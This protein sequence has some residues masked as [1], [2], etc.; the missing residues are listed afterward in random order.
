MKFSTSLTKWIAPVALLVAGSAY[1]TAPNPSEVYIE[2]IN[3]NGSGCPLGTVA[4]NLATD[5]KAFTLT[6]AE[7]IAEAG[8]HLSFRDGRKNCQLTID[9]HIPQGFQFS[10]GT[11]NYRGWVALDDGIRAAHT[12]SYYFQ[13]QGR[14]GRFNEYI[15][16]PNFDL[17]QFEEK[18]GLASLV[19]SPCGATRALN[20]NTSINVFNFDKRN[21]PDAQGAIGTD[22][23]D[24]RIEQKFGLRWRRCR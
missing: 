4:E 22:S 3:Y 16:G 18:V 13:G 12:T 23:I 14:T 15:W 11:F 10:I 24:G 7:Y 20:I 21:N 9:L 2:D 6:F 1:A 5:G 8:P 17:Y 19:W